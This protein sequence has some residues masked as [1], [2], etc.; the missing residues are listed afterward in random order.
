MPHLRRWLAAALALPLFLS[1]L[2]PAGGQPAEPGWEKVLN[3]FLKSEKFGFGG[4]GGLLVDHASGALILNMSDA[5]I[6]RST[7]QGKSFQRMNQEAIK[8]RTEFPG[9]M[10]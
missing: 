9:C 7:D 1:I 6:Y 2:P 3:E 5:G 4:L 8:G 10:Q